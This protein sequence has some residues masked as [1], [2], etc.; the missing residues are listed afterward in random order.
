MPTDFVGHASARAKSQ[1]TFL[2]PRSVASVQDDNEGILRMQGVIQRVV[3]AFALIAF[4]N[5][6]TAA[7]AADHDGNWTVR[8]ITE[9]GKCDHSS[10]YDVSVANGHIIYTNYTSLS[11]SGTISPQGDVM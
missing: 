3:L 9:Q 6:S 5:A 7:Y 10:S 11:L 2:L 8:V 1:I 4:A